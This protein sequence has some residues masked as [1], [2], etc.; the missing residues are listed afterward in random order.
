M[1]LTH[2]HPRWCDPRLCEHSTDNLD[3]RAAPFTWKPNAADVDLAV[4]LVRLDEIG[5]LNGPTNVMLVADTN[6][7]ERVEV[8]LSPADARMLAAA[9]V[10]AAER[11]EHERGE[12]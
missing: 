12:S 2:T 5:A 11:A 4:G 9:L 3:H 1:T 10:S 8:D 6:F 7:S